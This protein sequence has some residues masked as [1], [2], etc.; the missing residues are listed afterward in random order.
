VQ[1]V[2][3]NAA[4]RTAGDVGRTETFMKHVIT[5]TK[6]LS[7]LYTVSMQAT[8]QSHPLLATGTIV[9]ATVTIKRNKERGLKQTSK[10]S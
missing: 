5:S 2:R 4:P 3:K 10:C 1:T 9:D 8:Q 6:K 7:L